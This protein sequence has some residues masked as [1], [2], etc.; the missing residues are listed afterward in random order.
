MFSS[1]KSWASNEALM[2]EHAYRAEKKWALKYAIP[3]LDLV[4]VAWGAW[5]EN[6]SWVMSVFLLL[7]A[8]HSPQP[9]SWLPPPP[10]PWRQVQILGLLCHLYFHSR[11]FHWASDP[12]W[13][14]HGC[15]IYQ[16]QRMELLFSNLLLYAHPCEC[17]H[18]PLLPLETPGSFPSFLSLILTLV[19]LLPCDS[20][21]NISQISPLLLITTTSLKGTP[22]IPAWA[23][24]SALD[25][26]SLSVTKLRS[27]LLYISKYIQNPGLSSFA[28]RGTLTRSLHSQTQCHLENRDD[29]NTFLMRL[30]AD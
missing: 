18:H 2:T 11:V 30:S 5:S 22:P 25:L 12:M 19:C 1:L 27:V 10:C 13:M 28:S 24:A 7:A 29:C 23:A 17:V 4:Q 3:T 26:V 15:P 16:T 8:Q 21:S 9:L 14:S 6:T 20:I